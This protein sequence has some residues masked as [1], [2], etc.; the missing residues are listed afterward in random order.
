M[1]LLEQLKPQKHRQRKSPVSFS[2]VLLIYLTR[3]IAGLKYFYHVEPLLLQSKSVMRLVGFNGH[4]VKQ[5]V[6]R[7]GLDK[8]TKKYEEKTVKRLEA[9]SA[10]NSSLHLLSRLPAKHW[11]EFLTKLLPY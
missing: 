6:N 4:E 1:E 5:G 10:L 8:S 9:Q 7:R 2:T 11:N 3:M